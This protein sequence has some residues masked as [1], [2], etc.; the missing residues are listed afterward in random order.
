MD[1]STKNVDCLKDLP[2]HWV[3][4]QYAYGCDLDPAWKTYCTC[5]NCD[6]LEGEFDNTEPFVLILD[7]GCHVNVEPSSEMIPGD[8]GVW[9]ER[10]SNSYR[11]VEQCGNLCIGKII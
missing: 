3:K 5:W 8:Y 11:F 7:C 2:F 4:W 6:S 1:I 10:W 9:Q